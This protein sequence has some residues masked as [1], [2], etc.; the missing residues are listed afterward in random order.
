MAI[1]Q[2]EP[3]RQQATAKTHYGAEAKSVDYARKMDA[4]DPLKHLR[5]QFIIPSVTDISRGELSTNDDNAEKSIYFCGNS[6]GLQPKAVREYVNGQLSTWS[7]IAVKGHFQT[8]ESSPIK[9]W[10]HMAQSCAEASAPIVGAL[11]SEVAI[12]NSLTVNLHFLL[13]SF[14]R[15]TAKRNKI[16]MDWKAFP[17]DHYAIETQ[18]QWH[19]YD[20]KEAMVLVAPDDDF[21]ISTQKILD[22]IDEHAAD[23]ALFLLPGIQYYSGQYFDIKTITAHARSK[24]M[25]VG[26]DLAHAAGNVPVKLHDWDVDFACW[27]TYKYMNGGPGSIAG[28]FVHER[29]SKI[30]V[31]EDAETGTSLSF[32]LRLAGWY[33]HELKTRFNMDN[34]FVPIDGAG[35]WQ[36]S[37]P[38]AIDLASLAGALS[39]FNFTSIEALREKS[40]NLTSYAEFLFDDILATLSASDERQDKNPVFR[41][42]TPLDPEARGA[43]LCV[44]LLRPGLLDVVM[45]GLGD[46]GMIVDKRQP[47]VV[48][49]APVPLYNTFEEV[50]RFARKFEEALVGFLS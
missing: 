33:G 39:V 17:S 22:T 8:L 35:G 29:H 25:M 9:P 45:K 10:Q 46:A 23:A 30:R 41:I 20:P 50:Y 26:W 36:V 24:G 1:K 19:G 2:S 13:A 27:C 43:Q 31:T 3:T 34:Q 16:I 5:E 38:S 40:L 21:T 32:P 6:L 47:D 15:P 44:L 18:I 37:N 48:R 7:T 4:Q 14:Y 42:I 28:I 12:M 11:P 49:I